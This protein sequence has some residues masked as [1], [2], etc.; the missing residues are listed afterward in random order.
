[1][2]SKLFCVT[3]ILA[4]KMGAVKLTEEKFK[5]WKRKRRTTFIVFWLSHFLIGIFNNLELHAFYI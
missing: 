4:L 3:K 1:M 5:K 2:N